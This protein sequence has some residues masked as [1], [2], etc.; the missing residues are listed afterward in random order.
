MSSILI[1]EKVFNLFK[2][3][4]LLSF[5]IEFG[6]TFFRFNV[7][8]FALFFQNHHKHNRSM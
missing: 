8:A 2:Y 5:I 4:K 3:S 1:S 6:E 7:K